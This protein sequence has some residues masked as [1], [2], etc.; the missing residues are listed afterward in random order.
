MN[1]PNKQVVATVLVALAA[2]YVAGILTA[3]K[4][5]KE[6]RQ[7][8]REVTDRAVREAESRLKFAYSELSQLLAN[9]ADQAQVLTGKAKVELEALVGKANIAKEKVRQV[10]SSVHEGE[11]TDGDLNAAVNDV[12]STIE[13]LKKFLDKD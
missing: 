13:N 2:G 12:E 3:P 8:I 4:S 7:D 11:A 9:A 5:G 6:T 10:I 1:K